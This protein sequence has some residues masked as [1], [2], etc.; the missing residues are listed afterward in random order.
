[1]AKQK[2]SATEASDYLGRLL[3]HLHPEIELLPDL[4]GRCTQ[5]D[6]VIAGLVARQR[7]PMTEAEVAAAEADLV[8]NPVSLPERMQWTPIPP[9]W[10]NDLMD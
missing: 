6:N 10:V 9:A 1:M 4:I 5:I 8:K 7:I 2:D 3:K